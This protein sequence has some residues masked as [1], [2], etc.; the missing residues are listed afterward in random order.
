MRIVSHPK[1]PYIPTRP[2][3]ENPEKFIQLTPIK[4]DEHTRSVK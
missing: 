3:K 1:K 4:P 2:P